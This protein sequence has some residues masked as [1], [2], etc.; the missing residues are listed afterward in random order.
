[1]TISLSCG[2]SKTPVFVFNKNTKINVFNFSKT[3]F[4]FSYASVSSYELGNGI[5]FSK[6]S[7]DSF[8]PKVFFG[9]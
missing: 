4:Q 1:M 3:I 8:L 6:E 7:R 2:N 9:R 5:S